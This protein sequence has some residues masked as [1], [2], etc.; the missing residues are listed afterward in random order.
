MSSSTTTAKQP[1]AGRHSPVVTGG[2]RRRD[3]LRGLAAVLFLA[4]TVI[5]VPALLLALTGRPFARGLPNWARLAAR[6]TSPDDGSLLLDTLTVLTWTGWLLFTAATVLELI[7][8]CRGRLAPTLPGLA[9]LQ[10]TAGRLVATASLLLPAVTSS[11]LPPLPAATL[12]TTAIPAAA[13]A[14]DNPADQQPGTDQPAAPASH[15]FPSAAVTATATLPRPGC[16]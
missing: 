4:V 11:Q 10:A 14:A 8:T 16:R 9:G 13:A 1:A 2:R 3:R 12:V 6:I 5:G 15:Q 7:S